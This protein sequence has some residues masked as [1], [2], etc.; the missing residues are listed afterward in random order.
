MASNTYNAGTGTTSTDIGT[1]AW[2]GP[3]N[4]EFDDNSY[5]TCVLSNVNTSSQALKA[6]GFGITLP[7]NTTI[8]GVVVSFKRK[9]SVAS[10]IRDTHVY[11]LKNNVYSGNNKSAAAYW[12]DVEG[13]V[14]FGGPADLWGNTLTVSDVTNA[15]FG[16]LIACQYYSAYSGSETAYV[17]QVTL[18]LYYTVNFLCGWGGTSIS[19]IYWGTQQIS[20]VYH[21]TTRVA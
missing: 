10:V 8:D 5:A 12:S 6:T 11:L 9:A 13:T 21:G 4:I 18:T 20:R 7:P 19:N 15:N 3:D 17:D 16:A 2:S 1:V 14:S